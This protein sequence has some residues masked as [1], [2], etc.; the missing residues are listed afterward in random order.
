MDLSRPRPRSGSSVAAR[1]AGFRTLA[2]IG[3]PIVVVLGSVQL[4]HAAGAS[5][6]GS[7]PD[8]GAA[9]RRL[10]AGADLGTRLTARRA[11][12]IAE[13]DGKLHDYLKR[14]RRYRSSAFVKS[15]GIWQV[16]F[17]VE[18]REVAQVFVSDAAAAAYEVWI[19]PQVA[20]TMARGNEG[21]FGRKV[22]KPWVWV[23]LMVLFVLPFVDPRRPLKWLHL[24]LLV[25]LGFSVSHF[26]FNRGEIAASVP[27][28]YPVLAY[29]LVRMLVI[30]VRG[31]RPVAGRDALPRTL[32]P[33][34]WLAFAV[35]FLVGFRVGLNIVDSN[36]ID[37][38]YSGVIGADR[39]AHGRDL[40]GAFPSDNPSGDTYGP[41]NYFAYIPFELVLPWHGK[42]DDLPAAHA[43]AILFDLATIGALLLL[44][45]RLLEG[46][47]GRRLGVLLAYAWVTYPYTIFV[48]NSNANDTLVTLLLVAGMVG[49]SSPAWRGALLALASATKFAPLALAP[50]WGSFPVLWARWREKAVFAGTFLLA[51][52]IVMALVIFGNGLDRFWE[53]TL[54]FQLNRDSPFSIWGL[55]PV[56]Y[57]GLHDIVKVVVVT[58]AVGLAFVPRRKNPA[59]LAALS[60]AVLIGLQIAVNHWFYL[61]VVWFFPFVMVALLMR[62]D[63]C[64]ARQES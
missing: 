41:V 62:G 34:K 63:G 14:F 50:L 39:L 13:R 9:E 26:Y 15:P 55:H 22:T 42:W 24:D 4:A 43:A 20:W 47:M 8:A 33:A 40:Y 46:E 60:A 29:L 38:G 56:R 48:S 7:T 28:V 51:A 27:L 59:Q 1:V 36:V 16:S 53:R 12:E 30:G 6:A 61:Y 44:G 25:L 49:L 5:R 31:R 64:R 58:L 35:V 23:P 57:A 37:V 18:G 32:V 3:V 17:H 52:A 11:I 2:L 19:G 10:P 54:D 45:R 21:A